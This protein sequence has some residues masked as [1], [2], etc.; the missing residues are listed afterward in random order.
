MMIKNKFEILPVL[1]LSVRPS[2]PSIPS[3]NEIV[4]LRINQRRIFHV[5]R[6]VLD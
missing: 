6:R 1:N 4:L 3:L 2:L 5:Q